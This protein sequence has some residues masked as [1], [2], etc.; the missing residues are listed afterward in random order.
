M[1]GNTMERYTDAARR[2]HDIALRE[3]LAR[4]DNYIGFEHLE[5]AMETMKKDYCHTCGQRLPGK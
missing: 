1:E 3:A 5:A 4:G 2:V